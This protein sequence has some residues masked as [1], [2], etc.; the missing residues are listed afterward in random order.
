MSG[1]E[2]GR[3][4]GLLAL[5]VILGFATITIKQSREPPELTETTDP[6][7][8]SAG[9]EEITYGNRLLDAWHQVG[10]YAHLRDRE[11]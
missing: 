4:I 3:G 6:A 1:K 8:M 11:Y 7:M 2:L 10:E 9:P 5:A